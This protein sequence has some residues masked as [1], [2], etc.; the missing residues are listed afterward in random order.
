MSNQE[1]SSPMCIQMM[2][3]MRNMWNMIFPS[4]A[5]VVRATGW[6]LP[7]GFEEFPQSDGGP[8]SQPRQQPDALN[9]SSSHSLGLEDGPPA[10]S[11]RLPAEFELNDAQEFR[12]QRACVGGQSTR[13]YRTR[14]TLGR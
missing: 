9:E 5:H 3:M 2:D 14:C 12:S 1:V 7:H 13:S 10:G 4:I 8:H 6:K 11:S